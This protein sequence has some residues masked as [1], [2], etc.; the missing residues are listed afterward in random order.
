MG[1]KTSEE[2]KESLRSQSPEV[3]MDGEEVK[4]IVDHPGFQVGLQN[5]GVS[6][7]LEHDPKY[8]DLATLTS[9]LIN[10]EISRWTNIQQNEEDTLAMVRLMKGLGDYFCPCTYRC[11]TSIALNSSFAVSY[12]IDQKYNTDYHQRV[13]DFIKEAQRNDWFVTSASVDPKGDRSLKPSEQQDP[14]MYLHVIEKKKDGIVVRGAKPNVTC[15]PCAH[16]LSV[17]GASKGEESEKD[18]HVAFFTPIDA[19][20]IIHIS[21]PAPAPRESM[22]FENPISSNH[23]GMVES[24]V[25]FDDVFVPWERVFLCGEYEFVPLLSEM[26]GA[27]H[28]MNKCMCQW[29]LADLEIGATALMADYNGLS[30]APNI[31]ESIGEMIMSADV[32][33]SCAIASALEGWKHESGVYIPKAGPA[34]TGKVFSA[35][36]LGENRFFM[37][38]VAGG[39]VATM[40]SEKDIRNPKTK[41]YLEKY[42]KGRDGVPA[43]LRI[44]AIKLI[45]DIIASPYAGWRQAMAISGGG[46]V[47]HHRELAMEDYDLEQSIRRAKIAAGI[48]ID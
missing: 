8:R 48:K 19:K 14:D 32:L 29:A 44:R 39:L 16:M 25:I 1:I 36:K 41:G 12:A 46:D 7:D 4:N 5:A 15:G 18:Y 40:V 26:R 3:Y 33:H 31:R 9:P 13:V 2:Y 37:Q 47:R 20:G 27:L 17:R 35:R 45:E 23:G 21:K 43:E 22:D 34:C 42:Y 10:E 24:T 6:Y 11:L 28:A 38:D 30:E